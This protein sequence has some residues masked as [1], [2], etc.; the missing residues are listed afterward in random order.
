MI[1]YIYINLEFQRVVWKDVDYVYAH[2]T[3]SVM[4]V[5]TT[6]EDKVW[7]SLGLKMWEEKQ[8]KLR[9]AEAE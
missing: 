5:L 9:Q 6:I 2:K 7:Y 1:S 8:G 3:E 4:G